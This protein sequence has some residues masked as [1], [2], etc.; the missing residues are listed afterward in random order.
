M[1]KVNK[2][3][4]VKIQGISNMSPRQREALAIIAQSTAR[5]QELLP[6]LLTQQG[7]QAVS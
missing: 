4:T 6:K 5:L 7:E 2:Q 3:S 1:V